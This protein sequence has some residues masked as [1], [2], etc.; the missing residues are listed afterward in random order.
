MTINTPGAIVVGGKK[1]NIGDRVEVLAGPY[2]S[3]FAVFRGSSRTQ[4]GK[5]LIEPLPA[6]S[7]RIVI[8][9]ASIR[10]VTRP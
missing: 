3:R 9:R 6:C 10:K 7:T 5:V 2:A 8:A 1:I 4:P